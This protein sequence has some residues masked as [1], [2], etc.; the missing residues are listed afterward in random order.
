MP[1]DESFFLESLPPSPSRLRES[2]SCCQWLLFS[3]RQRQRD[4]GG[5]YHALS[6]ALHDDGWRPMGRRLAGQTCA[7][8]KRA[9]PCGGVRGVRCAEETSSCRSCWS[10][11]ASALRWACSVDG[12]VARLARGRPRDCWLRSRGSRVC[13]Q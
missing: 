4:W 5:T 9:R 6:E 2:C 11:R 10:S 13:G 7:A 1:E 3:I 12:G 8:R